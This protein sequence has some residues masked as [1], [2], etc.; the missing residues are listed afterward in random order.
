MKYFCKVNLPS[1]LLIQEFAINDIEIKIKNINSIGDQIRI[2]HNI[3]GE[4]LDVINDDLKNIGLP[5]LLYAQSYIRKKN[6]KQRIHVDGLDELISL[7][8]N[9]PLKGTKN[10]KFNWYDG[11]YKLVNTIQGDLYFYNVVWNSPPILVESLEILEP[12]LIR[13]DKPHNAVSSLEEDRWIFT[14]R[15]ENNPSNHTLLC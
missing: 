1:H 14:M 3:S 6:T 2:K 11:D 10:S 13:V 15:F 8:I 4:L 5:N 7:A 9:I 12:H